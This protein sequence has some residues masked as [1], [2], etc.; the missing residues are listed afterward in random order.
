[1]SSVITS[2]RP[3]N[4]VASAVTTAGRNRQTCTRNLRCL[5]PVLL[6]HHWQLDPTVCAQAMLLQDESIERFC[7]M[8]IEVKALVALLD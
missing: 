7:G 1:M 2:I 6:L 5:T 4:A 8:A 3:C